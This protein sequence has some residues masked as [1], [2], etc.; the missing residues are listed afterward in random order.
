M[1]TSGAIRWLGRH[2][3]NNVLFIDEPDARVS[4]T[5]SRIRRH[6]LLIDA[7]L[8]D[9][10]WTAEVLTPPGSLETTLT[11]VASAAAAEDHLTGR[12][13]D[14]IVLD[15][16]LPDVQGWDAVRRVSAAAPLVPILMFTRGDRPAFGG[17]VAPAG[18]QGCLIKGQIDA[19]GLQ[20]A[21]QAALERQAL[22]DALFIEQDRARVTL[23]SI[24]D[25]VAV[26]DATGR[27]TFL[28]AAAE[29]L[30]GWSLQEAAGRPMVEVCPMLD[31]VTRAPIPNPMLLTMARDR[32]GHSPPNSVLVHRD[33]HDI[34]ID[35][36]VGPIHD[37]AG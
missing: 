22:E 4:S 9:A 19:D 35:D 5:M 23:S 34:P 24:G 6:L 3:V 13:V 28:N 12:D 11:I 7:H 37:R 30:T 32:P 25:A 26:T 31:A 20:L 33:G 1:P 14:L 2:V 15:P 36:A 16:A 10:Q 27:L 29:R 8:S 18:F 17:G 21:V